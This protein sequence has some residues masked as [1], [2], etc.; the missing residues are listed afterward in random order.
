MKLSLM[1]EFV[2][3]TENQNYTKP[4]LEEFKKILETYGN[5]TDGMERLYG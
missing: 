5:E 1:R 3:L 2:K 4:V